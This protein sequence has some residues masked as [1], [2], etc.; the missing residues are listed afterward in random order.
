MVG[1]VRIGALDFRVVLTEGLRQKTDLAGQICYCT[2]EI[3][4]DALSEEQR[5]YAILL[6]EIVHGIFTHS[7]LNKTL[8]EKEELLED[9]VEIVAHG[10]L[11]VIRDN[12]GLVREIQELWR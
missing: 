2:N 8:N 7:K 5:Q 1:T 4:I 12:P 11:G 9:V 3:E 10:M 6:H